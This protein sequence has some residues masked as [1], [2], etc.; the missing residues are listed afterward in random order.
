MAIATGSG[1]DKSLIEVELVPGTYY[2]M[3]DTWPSPDCI[4][5]FTLSIVAYEPPPPPP[6]IL[7]GGDTC[8]DA[9]DLQAAGL[10][11]F[12]V[13]L[14]N[15]TNNYSPGEY[16]TSCTGY[17]AEGPES[18]YKINLGV[19]ENFNVCIEPSDGGAYSIDLSLYLVTD[20]LDPVNSCVIGDDSGNPECISYTA[21][22]AGTFYLM[23]DTYSSCGDGMTTVT[24]DAPIANEES[25]WGAVKSLYR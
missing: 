5:A 13:D 22:V 24:I 20:C 25:S 8:D 4:N 1:T 7:D 6:P 23:V 19:G 14:C 10:Q 21:D 9:V 18:V 12:R 3:A 15:Y 11:A 17:E 16:P 2:V